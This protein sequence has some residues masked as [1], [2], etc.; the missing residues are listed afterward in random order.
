MEFENKLLELLECLITRKRLL[1]VSGKQLKELLYEGKMY[2]MIFSVALINEDNIIVYK[3]KS[4]ISILMPNKA[5]YLE[6]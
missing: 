5:K 2:S 6:L 3:I 4:V 1:R